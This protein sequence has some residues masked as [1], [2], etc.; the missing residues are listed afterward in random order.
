MDKQK[1]IN[2]TEIIYKTIDNIKLPLKIYKPSDWKKTDSRAAI[3]FFFGG[4]WRGGTIDHFKP[5]SEY[6]VARGMIAITADYRVENRHGTSPFKCVE[7]GK[8]AV[9]W[10]EKHSTKLGIDANQIAVGGGSAGGHVAAST[11]LLPDED[12]IEE[13]VSSIPSAMVLFNPVLDTTENGYGAERLG[14]RAR[15]FSPL[16]HIDENVPPTIIFHGTDDTTVPFNNARMFCQ[17]MKEKGNQCELISY[18]G[19]GHGF[20]NQGRDEGDVAYYG[21]LKKAEKFLI[22]LGFIKE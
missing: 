14:K 9:S 11:V 1:K 4:G 3:I 16:H 12:Y 13:K 6:L 20:F 7:D 22:S 5:Q 19:K 8:S 21:T 18:E 15:D 2:V 10:V 17:K